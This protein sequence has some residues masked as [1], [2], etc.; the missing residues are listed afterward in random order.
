[1]FELAREEAEAV[2]KLAHRKMTG[3]KFLLAALDLEELQYV[4]NLFVSLMTDVLI[5]ASFPLMLK[6]SDGTLL[7]NRVLR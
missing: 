3:S 2:S 5:D 7:P 1:M 6:H 4:D